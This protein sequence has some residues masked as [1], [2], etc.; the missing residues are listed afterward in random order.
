M[1]QGRALEKLV[2]QL[3]AVLVGKEN[4]TITSPRRLRDAITGKLREHDVIVEIVD[5]HH[6]NR[7]AFECR[8]RSIPVGSPDVEA[9]AK[10][11]EHTRINRGILVSS[12]G[13]RPTATEKAEFLG[14][15]CYGIEEMPQMITAKFVMLCQSLDSR[16]TYIK[17]TAWIITELANRTAD[18]CGLISGAG[19]AIVLDSLTPYVQN[20]VDIIT[21]D[22]LPG[23]HKFNITFICED[24]WLNDNELEEKVPVHQ[25]I[26]QVEVE[27]RHES[28][29]FRHFKYS[30]KIKGS[31]LANVSIAKT[32]VGEHALNFVFHTGA[33]GQ[34]SISL[35]AEKS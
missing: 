26:A 1:K 13:F 18:L 10:K 5:G 4:V 23:N 25:M 34:V 22:F 33:D 31:D 2:A 6:I 17:K 8:D 11:C 12:S 32:P 30:D 7:I 35:T 29:Q 28:V 21:R 3:E 9:F 24:V 16:T 19:D 27:I 15:E 14:I 20:E